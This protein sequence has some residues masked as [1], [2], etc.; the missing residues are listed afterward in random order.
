MPR[1]KKTLPTPLRPLAAGGFIGFLWLSIECWKR[2]SRKVRNSRNSRKFGSSPRIPLRERELPLLR[3][4]E[5][6]QVFAG[7]DDDWWH[8]RCGGDAT[9]KHTQSENITKR[10]RNKKGEKK[11]LCDYKSWY[12]L[13]RALRI[14]G[15]SR[16][17]ESAVAIRDGCREG[18]VALVGGFVSWFGSSSPSS[19]TLLFFCFFF[20]SF[21]S[22]MDPV[23]YWRII[24]TREFFPALW[25]LGYQRILFW[26]Y[27]NGIMI[28]FHESWKYGYLYHFQWM[29]K[30]WFRWLFL[31]G[32]Y[33]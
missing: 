8:S 24:L 10:H 28:K 26:W 22:S 19:G 2:V 27:L 7:L 25:R 14:L 32:C 13:K 6:L 3:L 20:F 29:S 18:L 4:E 33:K 12:L 5:R 17:R 11:S 30:F 23:P 1:H 9:H 15:S 16:E 31:A 21:F